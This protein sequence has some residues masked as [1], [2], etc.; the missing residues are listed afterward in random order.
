MYSFISMLILWH[1]KYSLMI[2]P[3]ACFWLEFDTF[4]EAVLTLLLEVL[5]ATLRAAKLMAMIAAC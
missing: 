2:Q 5:I 3:L 4:C 1:A